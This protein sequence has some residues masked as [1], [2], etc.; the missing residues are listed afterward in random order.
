MPSP[1]ALTQAKKAPAGPPKLQADCLYKWSAGTSCTFS[2]KEKQTNKNPTKQNLFAKVYNLQVYYYIS[3]TFKLF[4]KSNIYKCRCLSV[5][6]SFVPKKCTF[7]LWNIRK[8][9]LQ[10]NYIKI[11]YTS[12][13]FFR[14]F[15]KVQRNPSKKGNYYFL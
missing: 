13:I 9:L 4:I 12:K 11:K 6:P 2:K 14:L 5:K 10:I 8:I 7:K 1:T 15:Y 3:H